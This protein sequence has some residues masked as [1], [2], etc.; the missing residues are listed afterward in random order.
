MGI[1]PIDET[2]HR[3]LGHLV[4]EKSGMVPGGV[5]M[6]RR[7]LTYPIVVHRPTEGVTKIQQFCPAC[8]SSV[9]LWVAS[10]RRTRLRQ[11]VWLIVGIVALALVASS[12]V[13]LARR[14]FPNSSFWYAGVAFGGFAL[15]LGLSRWWAVD[16]VS[17]ARD[18]RNARRLHSVHPARTTPATQPGFRP[19]EMRKPPVPV[20]GAVACTGLVAVA[21]LVDAVS[22]MIVGAGP[23]PAPYAVFGALV[24]GLTALGM[25]RGMPGFRAF[26]VF[27]GLVFLVAALGHRSAG[28]WGS[29]G[30]AAA[31]LWV[32]ANV[33][34]LV[35]KSSRAWFRP[36]RPSAR[37][38]PAPP[39]KSSVP[40][41]VR[42]RTAHHPVYGL[43]AGMDRATV[44]AR[45]GPPTRSVTIEEAVAR[46]RPVIAGDL[47]SHDEAWFYPDEPPGH[48]L[49]IVISDGVLD[50]VEVEV[51]AKPGATPPAGPSTGGSGKR[52]I[53]IDKDGIFAWTPNYALL[54]LMTV[55]REVPPVDA[56]RLHKEYEDVRQ[57]WREASL[58]VL[59]GSAFSELLKADLTRDAAAPGYLAFTV[60]PMPDHACGQLV[61]LVDQPGT[62]FGT[63]M[64]YRV[65]RTVRDGQG[66]L[67][68]V[69]SHQPI[70]SRPSRDRPEEA[71][72]RHAPVDD[73]STARRLTELVA[74]HERLY[75]LTRDKR[76][77][78][79]A[80]DG[81]HLDSVLSSDTAR[82]GWISAAAEIR[83]IGHRLNR[84]GGKPRMQTVAQRA[85]ELRRTG[86]TVRLI[87]VFWD[88]IGDWRA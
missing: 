41:N 11:R 3:R 18:G 24:S 26:V 34:V 29:V 2:V 43:R 69:R 1:H 4:S 7:H 52:M 32:V 14:H 53:R 59:S 64:A 70:R 61:S 40:S 75:E 42:E 62:S 50:S 9:G 76:L 63:G 17:V 38:P 35:P 45:L 74:A 13:A 87:E 68:V 82:E 30:L 33:L 47:R 81:R 19:V 77:I 67:A 78:S 12:L 23:V 79:D 10:A 5:V 86:D 57:T 6:T 55:V 8:K 85:G 36:R 15:L 72:D 83:A 25:R 28:V 51:M 27:W 39:D 73:E 22:R 46:S 54:V 49:N 58:D 48:T 16:G 71:E 60:T 84:E 80:M 65:W 56:A 37:Q 44:L 31:A 21:L 66:Q 20:V 88:R